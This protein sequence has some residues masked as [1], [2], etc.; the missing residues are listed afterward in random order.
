MECRVA[1]DLSN[2][3]RHCDQL[4]SKWV[5]DL[6]NKRIEVIDLA[7]R[8]LDQD[9][10]MYTFDTAFG[11]KF[12]FDD[13]SDYEVLMIALAEI[14]CGNYSDLKLINFIVL[15]A[16]DAAAYCLYDLEISELLSDYYD[17]LDMANEVLDEVDLL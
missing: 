17:E 1:L 8:I 3:E 4:E 14:E 5:S 16:L 6:D 15:L 7:K 13:E 12:D 11:S 2:H 10:D 9:V